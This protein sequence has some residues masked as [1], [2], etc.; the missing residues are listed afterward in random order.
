MLK[1]LIMKRHK[2]IYSSVVSFLLYTISI[3]FVFAYFELEVPSKILGKALYPNIGVS[4]LFGAGLTLFF[5][6]MSKKIWW[7][8]ENGRQK[9][10]GYLVGTGLPLFS[11]MFLFVFSYFSLDLP[12][13]VLWQTLD[14]FMVVSIITGAAVTVF[15]YLIN[16]KAGIFE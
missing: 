8:D 7:Q 12:K 6:W 9:E 14:Q 2:E 3:L 1:K 10:K 5:Y 11:I 13:D 4:I 15:G 16:K